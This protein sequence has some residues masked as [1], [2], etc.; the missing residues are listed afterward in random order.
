M[1]A[2]PREVCREVFSNLMPRFEECLRRVVAH[3]GHVISKK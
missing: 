3:L 1:I 2:I